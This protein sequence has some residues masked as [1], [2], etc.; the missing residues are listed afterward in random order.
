MHWIFDPD[1]PERARDSMV[2][3]AIRVSDMTGRRERWTWARPNPLPLSL[4]ANR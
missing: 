1:V 2:I 4:L 3:G